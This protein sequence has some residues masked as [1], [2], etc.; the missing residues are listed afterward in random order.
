MLGFPPEDEEIFRDII[1]LVLDLIDLPP[2]V[3]GPM[4][5]PVSEYFEKQIDDHIANP[6]DDLTTYLLNVEVGGK[7]LERHHVVGNDRPD[8]HRRHRHDVVGDRLGDLAP[9][10]ESR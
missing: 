7:K 10:E 3:R 8:P 1:H 9:R 5:E 2:E 4:F 6:R